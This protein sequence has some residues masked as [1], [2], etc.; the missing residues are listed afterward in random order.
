MAVVLH[1]DAAGSYSVAGLR[2]G[3]YTVE[4]TS[5]AGVRSSLPSVT[6]TVGGS[7]TVAPT[8]TGVLTLSKVP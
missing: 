4:I 8:S 6:A 3:T 7:V 1:I 5:N 2:P